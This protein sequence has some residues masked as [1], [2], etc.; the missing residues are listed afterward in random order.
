MLGQSASARYH[1]HL[2]HS[3]LLVPLGI[4]KCEKFFGE[5]ELAGSNRYEQREAGG[6]AEAESWAGE[7]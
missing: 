7:H 3:P 1:I 4:D 6:A 5:S 2:P